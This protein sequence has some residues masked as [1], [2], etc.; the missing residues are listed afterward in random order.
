MC[1]KLSILVPVYGVERYIE[2]CAISLFEQ[3]Y[4]NIE[5]VFVDDC[6]PDGSID[7]LRQV[8]VRYPQRQAQVTIIRHETNGGLGAARATA[9]AHATGDYV[10]HVDSD[11]CLPQEACTCLMD[12]VIDTDADVVDGGYAETCHGKVIQT[13]KPFHGSDEAY[14][15]LMLC[16][17]VVSNRIW[18]RIY[19]RG[20]FTQHGI[21]SV[22][23][24]DYSE[25][26]CVVPRLLIHAK[27]AYTDQVVYHYRTDNMASYTHQLTAKNLQS[28][29][30]ATLIVYDY[31]MT[32]DTTRQYAF[33]LQ[34][35]MLNL[36]RSERK[37]KSIIKDHSN[38]Q[39][40]MEV[41][42]PKGLIIRSLAACWQSRCPY[43]VAN[44]AYLT[45]RRIYV[46]CISARWHK[47]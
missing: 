19:R 4:T 6:S 18:G 11:D 41:F 26:F 40:T 30:R 29:Q 24:V 8:I 38:G 39:K 34:L 33:A 35:G 5:Y 45:V 23:G 37:H 21:N 46:T 27:R 13:F 16:Q 3:S 14:L 17:N 20:L 44:I 28:M 2:A 43:S 15:K 42:H 22:S 1:M 31:F 7:L 10:M 36:L 9:L 12:K 47:R 32:N 25:D